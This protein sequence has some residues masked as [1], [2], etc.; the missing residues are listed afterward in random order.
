MLLALL[1]LTLPKLARAQRE[2]RLVLRMFAQPDELRPLQ[3]VQRILGFA[4]TQL[5]SDLVKQYHLVVATGAKQ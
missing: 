3:F 2:K 1:A 4:I 5:W